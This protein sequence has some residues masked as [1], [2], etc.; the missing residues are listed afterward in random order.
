MIVRQLHNTKQICVEKQELGQTPLVIVPLH[1]VCKQAPDENHSKCFKHYSCTCGLWNNVIN[2]GINNYFHNLQCNT[3]SRE[4]LK[5][6]WPCTRRIKAAQFKLPDPCVLFN[7]EKVH[8]LIHLGLKLC[9]NISDI[10]LKLA[11]VCLGNKSCDLTL[12]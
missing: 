6:L 9:W 12:K 10:L 3:V 2:D 8:Y 5:E 11:T 7:Q 4:G 1:S